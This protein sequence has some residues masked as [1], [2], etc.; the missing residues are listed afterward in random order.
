MATIIWVNESS[1]SVKWM[2][3]N[4]DRQPEGN[5]IPPG[6]FYRMDD[7]GLTMAGWSLS[8]FTGVTLSVLSPPSVLSAYYLALDDLPENDDLLSKLKHL[9]APE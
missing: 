8:G 1:Q 4:Q 7:A 9:P 6:Q 2:V 5:L 3:I